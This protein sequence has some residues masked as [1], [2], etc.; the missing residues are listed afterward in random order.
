MSYHIF[1]PKRNIGF[2]ISFE[3]PDMTRYDT[4]PEQVY[5]Y[6]TCVKIIIFAHIRKEICLT[7]IFSYGSMI[8]STNCEERKMKYLLETSF[9]T[10]QLKKCI[11]NRYKSPIVNKEKVT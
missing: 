4:I 10:N 7:S 6:R 9:S 11:L 8:W 2:V 1:V 3:M 5:I